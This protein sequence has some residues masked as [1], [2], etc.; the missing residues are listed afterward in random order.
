VTRFHVEL[1]EENVPLAEAELV[2][3][4]EALGGGAAALEPGD[5]P[6][7]RAVELSG[8]AAAR[9]LATRIAFSRRILFLWPEEARGDVLA[10]LAAEA[11][12][13]GSASFRPWGHERGGADDPRLAEL[14]GAWRRGG[15]SI[16]LGAPAHRYYY[17]PGRS[18]GWRLGEEVA[19]VDRRA[20]DDRR[21]PRLPFQRPV[22]LAP[23][24]GRAAANL[25]RVRPGDRVVDPFVGTGA[26][27]LEAALLGARVAGVDRDP[28]M[29]KGAI[30]NL[31][32]FRLEAQE[33]IVA[34]AAEALE[35]LGPEPFDAV[36][37]DPPY[38][39]ASGSHGEP[40]ADLLARVLPLYARRLR[41]GGRM[42]VVLPG[43]E[44]PV[45]P[46]LVR[47]LCLPDRVHRS[48]TREFRV[49]ERPGGESEAER[50]LN[51]R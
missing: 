27:L 46:P 1:S 3:A 26:L 16:D 21:M 28:E 6:G 32:H 2:A 22:S 34:D 33:L 51:R 8:I 11:D 40:P 9:A 4:A 29:V 50:S 48:L 35:R 38:G 18:D 23:R 44:D 42:V 41:P 7:F 31:A 13:G 25:A 30:R 15:G 10:R 36:L 14:A 12:R 24:L 45:G 37:T 5:P 39:R 47:V 49:Y 43:G 17:D 20:A 19:A